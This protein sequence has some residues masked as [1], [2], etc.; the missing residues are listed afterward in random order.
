MTQMILL[1]LINTRL[2]STLFFFQN[3]TKTFL[4]KIF[5]LSVRVFFIV[6]PSIT[7]KYEKV[8]QSE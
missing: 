5:N 7:R 1:Q 4:R 6:Q 2:I 3:H 8:L